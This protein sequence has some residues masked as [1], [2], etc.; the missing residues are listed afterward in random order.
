MR[1]RHFQRI[2]RRRRWIILSVAV[3]LV[4]GL[5]FAIPGLASARGE[6]RIEYNFLFEHT[7]GTTTRVTGTGTQN[8][9]FIPDAGGT[10]AT[11]PSGM[12]VHISCSDP[13]TDGW[14]VKQGP[15]P[16]A[17]SEWRIFWYYIVH[18]EGTQVK[19]TCGT[20]EPPA[21]PPNP[22]IDIEKATN[23]EDA[24]LPTGPQVRV[25]STV[26]WTYVVT[27]TGNTALTD[28]V[29]ADDKEG[30][31][32][33]PQDRLAVG[34][35]MTCTEQGIAQVGQYANV[36]EVIAVGP[37]AAPATPIEKGSVYTFLFEHTDGTTTLVTG[38]ATQNDTF[39]PD[40]GGTSATDPSGM[41]VHVS[42]SDPFTDGWGVKQGPDPVVDSEW[43]VLS[44]YIVKY[45]KGEIKKTCGTPIPN[46]RTVR[47][48]DPSHYLGVAGDPG[49]DIEKATNGLDADLPGTGPN[50]RVGDPVTWTYV[51]RNTGAVDLYDV[52]VNDDREGFVGTIDFLPVGG[53]R[54]FTKTGYALAGLPGGEYENWGCVVGYTQDGV[55]VEDCDPSH[56]DPPGD[57]PE[58]PTPAGVDLEKATNG[59]DADQGTGPRIAIGATVTWTYV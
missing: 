22:A 2:L 10:S 47:D 46:T 14:G 43:R 17:D 23:G 54:T 6:K 40:A 25:G 20:P 19:K 24:D 9:T 44:Y 51:V 45:D 32:T 33:C 36:A 35:S 21:P 27:N 15:D 1:G 39:I 48:S 4:A 5:L 13:F 56:Y 16:I 52:A 26:T 31:I 59:Q 37:A 18:Y 50:L 28:V 12:I 55:E 3:M 49:I 8:D 38:T 58:P 41:I 34:E 30:S 11:D 57:Y 53:S 7:D 29:V 42:C